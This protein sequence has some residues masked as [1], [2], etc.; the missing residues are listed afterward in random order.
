MLYPPKS[1]TTIF[2]FLFLLILNSGFFNKLFMYSDINP[3]LSLILINPLPATDTS[4]KFSF[5]ESSLQI[6]CA[7]SLGFFSNVFAK[8]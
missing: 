8:L 7:M 1:I 6:I 2:C 4:L 3:S 5:L